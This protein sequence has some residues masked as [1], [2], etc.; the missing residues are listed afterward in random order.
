MKLN[1]PARLDAKPG[2]V[3][4]DAAD[5]AKTDTGQEPSAGLGQDL[6]KAVT[7][8][9]VQLSRRGALEKDD[10]VPR[11]R[12]RRVDGK[13]SDKL[14]VLEAVEKT[15]HLCCACCNRLSDTVDICV[16]PVNE[17]RETGFG[18]LVHQACIDRS[19]IVDGRQNILSRAPG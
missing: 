13:L 18:N 1:L 3:G 15:H 5:G 16:P 4:S 8:C 2:I 6:L 11:V 7:K 14:V 10:G 12:V 19:V 9:K 17:A